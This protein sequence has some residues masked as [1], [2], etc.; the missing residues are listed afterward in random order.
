MHPFVAFV[1]VAIIMLPSPGGV[2]VASLDIGFKQVAFLF[3]SPR[4]AG[5]A[6]FSPGRGAQE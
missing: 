5:D 2:G 4:G 1:T 3:P 6:S